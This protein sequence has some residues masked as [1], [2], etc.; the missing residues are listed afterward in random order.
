MPAWRG[1]IGLL[2]LLPPLV[3]AR[4]EQV[5]IHLVVQGSATTS[6]VAASHTVDD[7]HFCSAA[8]D[9]W[10]APDVPDT[11]GPPFPFYRLVFGQDE[12]EAD[13]DSPGPS[14]GL[15][16]SDYDDET[17]THSDPVNDSIEVMLNGH[18][19]VGH[20]D[21]GDPGYRLSVTFRPDGHG[22]AF[23]ARRLH[24]S[25]TGHAV[26]DLDGSWHCPPVAAG[27][28]EQTISVHRLFR[29]AEPARPDPVR[30]RLTRFDVPC[31]DRGCARWRVTDEDSGD[32]YLA[33]VDF[34]HLRLARR[35]RR[36]AERGEVDLLIDARVRSSRP[37]LVT[38]LALQGVEPGTSPSSEALPPPEVLPTPPMPP[39]EPP[40]APIPEA[41]LR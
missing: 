30:L 31:L 40:A 23:V 6:V 27:L 35:L 14:I 29:G 16:L 3:A 34:S 17:R 11:R 39:P 28:P 33:R 41:S 24:E 38:A 4:A 8:A 37:P 9:P 2:C 5:T 15:A 19:F 22:G 26:I 36:E 1:A 20:A 21:M 25:G 18:H 13:L 12:A 32:A 7:A 10:S